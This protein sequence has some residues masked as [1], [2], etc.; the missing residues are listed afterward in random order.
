[1]SRIEEPY[2][3]VTELVRDTP[4]LLN[5][6]GSANLGGVVV[7]PKGESYQ[8]IQGPADFMKKLVGSMEF[9]KNAHTTLV[10]AF[11]CSYFA[12]LV[13]ARAVNTN[14]TSGILIDLDKKSTS[15]CVFNNGVPITSG[16]TLAKADLE[17]L[18]TADDTDTAIA[19]FGILFHTFP[20]T[21]LSKFF[22]DYPQY[23]DYKTVFIDKA[24]TLDRIGNIIASNVSAL[25][26]FGAIYTPAS[27]EGTETP[28]SSEGTEAPAKSTPK[29]ASKSGS[30]SLTIPKTPGNLLI[31][32]TGNLGDSFKYPFL[33]YKNKS[34][35]A[36]EK[37]LTKTELLAGGLPKN[38]LSVYATEVMGGNDPYKV[39]FSKL[40][41][42]SAPKGTQ[43][44]SIE[45]DD[46]KYNYVI[47]LNPQARYDG[48]SCFV[49]VYNNLLEDYQFKLIIDPTT[50]DD[51][52]ATIYEYD[53]SSLN[54]TNKGFG[55][56]S[57]YDSGASAKP[58]CF[59]TAINKLQD[60]EE[61]KIEYIS[62]FG[63]SDTTYLKDYIN[64]GRT[65]NWFAPVSVPT[66]KTNQVTIEQFGNS[67]A[68]TNNTIV[69][70]PNDLDYNFI[71]TPVYIAATS[72]YYEKVYANRA[73]KKEYAPLFE[74]TNGVLTYRN[75]VCMLDATSRTALLN[76]MGGPINFLV[77]NSELKEYYFNDN[78]CHTKT[79]NVM[80]EEMNRRMINRIN[81]DVAR[82]MARFK[83]RVNTTTT[84]L[85][86]ETLIKS[87]MNQDIMTQEYKPVEYD[88][89]CDESN[90]TVDIINAN[91][92]AVHLRIRLQGSIKFIDVLNEIFPLG[93]DFD[94]SLS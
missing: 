15:D 37:T 62:E 86:V 87:Y 69:F 25:D 70:G 56:S 73:N 84:R 63:Y 58:E 24:D 18:R 46:Y 21:Y 7:S 59:T 32:M 89:I 68:D 4:N 71:G 29:A 19:L 66:S 34:Y 5:L 43:V 49:E 39:T 23:A 36:S 47:S 40:A 91:K 54:I 33:T 79:D 55:S 74:Q 76:A 82:L 81:K 94:S 60:Q 2:V 16:Y 42:T 41:D 30:A 51:E 50:T 64:I 8:L 85:D 45:K 26:G 14:M 1:M 22:F 9:P 72:K 31:L 80:K 67:L 92:L 77:Y 28:A 38:Y 20:T 3:H 52:L 83:G 11:Y 17:A 90:N 6:D 27:S 57:L 88:V 78:R 48:S 44:I 93:V 75:P 65:K 53:L 13:I 61:F 10:N 12:P 35:T